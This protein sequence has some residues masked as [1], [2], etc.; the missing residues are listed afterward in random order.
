MFGASVFSTY[1]LYLRKEIAKHHG[2]EIFSKQNKLD[3]TFEDLLEANKNTDVMK[4]VFT[5]A[6]KSSGNYRKNVIDKIKEVFP[7][8]DIG[9]LINCT[10]NFS[11]YSA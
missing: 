11:H 1:F 5:E 7:E 9:V 6:D 4:I 3:T 2:L 10:V 8:K